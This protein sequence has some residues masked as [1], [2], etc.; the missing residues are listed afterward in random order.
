MIVY[1]FG[2]PEHEACEHVQVNSAP[3]ERDRPA[4]YLTRLAQSST[5]REYKAVAMA[6]MAIDCGNTVA[7]L[8]C[9]PG[10][11]L[12]A[13]ADATG[14]TGAVIGI[15]SDP[16]AVETAARVVEGQPWVQVRLADVHALDLADASADRVHT[17]RVLQHVADPGVVVAEA[18]RVL[19]PGGRAVFAEPDYDTLVIDYPDA[20]VMRAYRAFITDHVIRNAS[21]GRQLAG[22]SERLGFVSSDAVPVTS[23]FRDVSEADRIFG[24]ERVTRRAVAS[25]YLDEAAADAWLDHLATQPFFAAATLFV[26]VALA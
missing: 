1:M 15:D 3:F 8:G 16:V 21:I 12:V 4:D 2:R 25:G 26:V 5:G 24:F 18:L 11:D 19:R 14:P 10:T 6:E 13:L 23:V 7:D 9:G 20:R 17:D 22:L